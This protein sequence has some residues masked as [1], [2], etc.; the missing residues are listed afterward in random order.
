ME[1]PNIKLEIEM[2][3]EPQFTSYVPHTAGLADDSHDRGKM[4]FDECVDA[5]MF[6]ADFLSSHNLLDAGDHPD[7]THKVS[8]GTEQLLLEALYLVHGR[9]HVPDSANAGDTGGAED[10]EKP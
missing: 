5:I 10:L 8:V 3:Y 4:S 9:W 6:L 7:D 2:R 1:H